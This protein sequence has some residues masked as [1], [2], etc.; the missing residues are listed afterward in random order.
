MPF[1]G[2]E[3][4]ILAFERPETYGLDRA[5]IGIGEFTCILFV[6]AVAGEL[7]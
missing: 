5:S 1:V 3:L 6:I 7:V 2:F 4:A